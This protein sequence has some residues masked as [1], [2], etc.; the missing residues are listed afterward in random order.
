MPEME[1]GGV[2]G[3]KTVKLNL[4]HYNLYHAGIYSNRSTQDWGL[5][6]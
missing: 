3:V 6:K 5:L 1:T 4:L 2:D